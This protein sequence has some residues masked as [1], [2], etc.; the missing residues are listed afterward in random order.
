MTRSLFTYLL[1]ASFALSGVLSLLSRP[2]SGFPQLVSEPLPWTRSPIRDIDAAGFLT[3]RERLRCLSW[4][5]PSRKCPMKDNW[6][7]H[8]CDSD[9]KKEQAEKDF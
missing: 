6:L 5:K 1:L 7:G 9:N 2:N 4:A 3:H 8:R